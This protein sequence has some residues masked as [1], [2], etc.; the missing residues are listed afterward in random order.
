MLHLFNPVPSCQIH[1]LCIGEICGFL[2]SDLIDFPFQTYWNLLG[3]A[4]KG[5]EKGYSFLLNLFRRI[6]NYFSSLSI[7]NFYLISKLQKVMNYL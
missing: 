6:K 7:K 1:F 3:A 2:A 4:I 5:L